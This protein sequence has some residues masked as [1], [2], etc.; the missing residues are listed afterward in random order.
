[1]KRCPTC[2]FSFVNFYR[3]CD[4]D[5][6]DLVDDPENLPVSPGISAL[7]AATQSPFLRLVKSPV[8]SMV[9]ALA[10]LVS[11]ALLIGYYDAASQPNSIAPS[12]A[13]RNSPP[14][15][16]ASLVP[17]AQPAAEPPARPS[18]RIAT[19]APSTSPNEV[20]TPTRRGSDQ[21][22]SRSNKVSTGSG[23]DRV[24]SRSEIS[25]PA[26]DLSSTRERSVTASR[27]RARLHTSPS[28]RNQQSSP[29]IALQSHPKDKA[30]QKEH[31][32]SSLQGDS[33]ENANR[34]DSKV[35]AALKTTWHILKKP[36]KF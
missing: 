10:G 4:F 35:T 15:Y 5:G 12:P 11:S 27:S 18:V 24:T 21:V 14:N 19:R 31:K 34:K 25:K 13:S 26:K 32:E 28:I 30:L 9:L 22:T 16:I 29:E 6:T 2:D 3:V 36:F 17:P 8:F 20:S 33:K 1:M 7:V 23:S